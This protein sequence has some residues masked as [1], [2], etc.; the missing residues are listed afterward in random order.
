MSKL[1]V[2]FDWV[3]QNIVKKI[4]PIYK[5]IWFV[6]ELVL[7]V[8]LTFVLTPLL[9]G[10]FNSIF[11]K[12]ISLSDFILLITAAFIIFYTFETQKMRKQMEK[13]KEAEF[14]PVVV[15]DPSSSNNYYMT[16]NLLYLKNDIFV[17]SLSNVG[18]GI[19]KELIIYMDSHRVSS[20]VSIEAHNE[21]HG[22]DFRLS[23]FPEELFKS[24]ENQKYKIFV[25]LEYKDIYENMFCTKATLEKNDRGYTMSKKWE[26]YQL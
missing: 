20:S 14:M 3:D 24:F 19:A 10:L 23:D 22:F 5:F 8:G 11:Q 18:K 25:R 7:W 21:A 9:V 12:N 13:S 26:F 1:K 4:I 6:I 15:F 2:I 17:L 16:N